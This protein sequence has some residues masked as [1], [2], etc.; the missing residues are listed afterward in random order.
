MN[1]LAKGETDR[2][3]HFWFR[4]SPVV[5]L[6]RCHPLVVSLSKLSAAIGGRRTSLCADERAYIDGTESAGGPSHGRS[7][8]RGP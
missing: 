5:K 3:L 6:K 4:S 8:R 1:Q 7:D 2:R